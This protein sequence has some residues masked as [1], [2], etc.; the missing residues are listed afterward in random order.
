MAHGSAN[1]HRL[2]RGEGLAGR[3]DDDARLA[4]P[5][6]RRECRQVVSPPM[7]RKRVFYGRIE[8]QVGAVLRE[9]RRR[10]GIESLEGHSW[11]NYIHMCLGIPLKHS[12]AHTVAFLQ[13]A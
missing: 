6:P 11:P 9:R 13:E 5:L 3:E 2:L 4:E 12:V 1:R 7:Y 10:K 8:K